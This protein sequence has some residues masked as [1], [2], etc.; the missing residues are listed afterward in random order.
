[1]LNIGILVKEIQNTNVNK[2]QVV[3]DLVRF[4]KQPDNVPNAR[5]FLRKIE[6]GWGLRLI[7]RPIKSQSS[8]SKILD[9]ASEVRVS[10]SLFNKGWKIWRADLSLESAKRAQKYGSPYCGH[11]VIDPR[12]PKIPF[13]Q[14]AFDAVIS[15]GPFDFGF[16]NSHMLLSEI[17][18]LLK[19][20][21]KFV[22]SIS[23]P[24]SPY[25]NKDSIQK[26]CFW[27]PSDISNLLFEWKI[28]KFKRINVPQP[29]WV[30][31]RIGHTSRIPTS[32]F[33]TFI[34]MPMLYL[35]PFV[36]NR[37]ASY[38]ILSLCKRSDS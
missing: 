2:E 24:L 34:T 22:F 14:E 7:G 21:G 16:L 15:I 8:Q 35:C 9:I 11:V 19:F 30:Y 32:V 33:D 31:S 38:I 13:G 10:N 17:K 23:T 5:W 36:P 37:W 27:S 4:V 6:W 3:E 18:A 28:G 12:K 1:M 26:F 29:R 25:C 20:D